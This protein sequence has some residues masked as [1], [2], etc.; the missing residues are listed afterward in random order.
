MGVLGF[1]QGMQ[2][3]M[4]PPVFEFQ[5]AF[6]W[7]GPFAPT[8]F[9]AN[10][11]QN[12]VDVGNT[13]T[14]IL[15][16]GLLL[17]KQ[18]ATNQW[19]NYAATNTDGSE[20]AQGIL[21]IGFN[22]TNYLTSATV[23]IYWGILTG[24]CVKAANLIGLDGMA[25]E[26]MRRQFMFDDDLPGRAWF[27]YRRFQNK[28]AAY[29]V[30]TADNQSEFTNLG[31]AGSVVLTL[32]PIANGLM[33]AA[34]CYAAQTLRFTSNEGNNILGNGSLTGASVSANA[35]GGGMMIYSNPAATQ[36]EVENI[37]S[38]NTALNYP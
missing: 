35:I 2:F 13:P 5:S 10:I 11:S 18:T 20:V 12:T 34:R 29:Q 33:Y 21:L 23:P 8:F 9:V 1:G 15:R 30:T 27:P 38:S 16:M 36:W 25:R 19:I 37:S 4:Q 31:A 32:P 28:T 6:M 24:G 3:G 14:T 22:M 17:G 7:N 26:Q